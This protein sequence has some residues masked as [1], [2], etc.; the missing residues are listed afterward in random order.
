MSQQ[1]PKYA[2]CA[3]FLEYF[4]HFPPSTGAKSTWHFVRMPVCT[5]VTM[6]PLFP[7][8]PQFESWARALLLQKQGHKI[9][10]LGAMPKY[11]ATNCLTCSTAEAP[12]KSV[13]KGSELYGL[14]IH[15]RRQ[16]RSQFCWNIAWKCTNQEAP[17]SN[18]E[19][20]LKGMEIAWRM[21][22][23]LILRK[24]RDK[25]RRGT[26]EAEFWHKILCSQHRVSSAGK[27]WPCI[28]CTCKP[29]PGWCHQHWE[30]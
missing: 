17:N 19:T 8:V 16:V 3:W 4:Q 25:S 29:L 12:I 9:Q 2:Q 22:A 1:H 28:K 5:S 14:L 18:C 26:T 21:R 27:F 24:T 7:S 11:I 6:L 23:L 20:D 30:F 13:S 10:K 15:Q